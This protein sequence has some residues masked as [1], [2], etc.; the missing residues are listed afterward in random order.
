M[1]FCEKRI[2]LAHVHGNRVTPE[3]RQ[4]MTRGRLA[5]HRYFKQGEPARVRFSA[6]AWLLFVPFRCVIWIWRIAIA[7]WRGR[8]P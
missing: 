3:Q 8:S 1:G 6:I 7:W 4:A 5:H 2:L